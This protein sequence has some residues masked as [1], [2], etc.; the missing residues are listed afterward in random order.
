MNVARLED[1]NLETYGDYDALVVGSRT[2]TSRALHG[3]CRRLAGA[4]T[5]LE[6]A[7]GDRM[8]L[9]LPSGFEL[10][11]AFTAVLRAGGV[12]VV[13][14]PNAPRA[15]IERV[16][17]H[18][19]AKGLIATLARASSLANDPLPLRIVV[20]ANG[21]NQALPDGTH[22]F[23]RLLEHGAPL[24]QAVPRAAHDLAQLI[25]TSGTTGT[26][27]GIVY[28]HGEIALR[29]PFLKAT[30]QINGAAAKPSVR[31]MALPPAHALGGSFFFLRL[32][33]KSTIIC[34]DAFDARQF[35]AAVDRHRVTTTVLVPSMCEALLAEEEI[36]AYD[37]SSLRTIVTGGAP[38]S[39]S[40][41]ERFEAKFKKRLV[42]T[43]GLTEAPGMTLGSLKAK[44]GSAGRLPP[45]VD[46]RFV[47]ADG[48]PLAPGATGEIQFKKH[49]A[50]SIYRPSDGPAG[51]TESDDEWFST[52]DIGYLDADREL[53][54]TGRAKELI[55][56]GGVKINPQEIVDVVLRLGVRECAVVG[57]P[58][59]FLGEEAVACVVPGGAA[60]ITEEEV[61]SHCRAS[62]DKRK[63]PLSVQFFEGLP[64]TELGKIR[65]ESLRQEVLG[66]RATVVE[67]DL[68][69]GLR[70]APPA[71]RR[72]LLRDEIGAQLRRI[73]QREPLVSL[74][75]ELDSGAPFG[76]LGL[77]SLGALELANSLSVAIGRP[78]SATVAFD[79]PTADALCDE[80]LKE[81]FPS[82]G[83]GAAVKPT[84][85]PAQREPVA[86]VGIGC[87]LPG[88]EGTLTDPEAF[89][90]SLRDGIDSTRVVPSERW[91]VEQFYDPARGTPGK[92]Y[93]R[94]GS[95]IDSVDR[96]DADFF[97]ITPSE[98]KGL[99]PQQRLLL[100][101]SWEAL[102]HSGHDPYSLSGGRTG[103][104]VGITGSTYPSANF[105]GVM[106]C[107][108]PGRVSQ[109]LN[110]GG[111]SVAI[112]TACSS[113]LVA[114]HLA[115]QSLRS[116]ECDVAL[117]GGVN[118][119]TSPRPFVYLSAIQALAADGRCKAFDA[120]ADGYGRG[121]G[122]VIVV[123]KPLSL[124]VRDHD[125]IIAVI[126][127]SAVCHDGRRQSLTAPNGAAQ[128][129]VIAA[130]L[131][132]AGVEASAVDYLEAHGTGTPLGDP[133]EVKAAVEVLGQN[134]ERPLIIGS[135]KTN[136]GHTE[137]A[138]GA[139]A[140]A[141]VAL[142]LEHGEIP[143]LLHL[144]HLNPL[145]DPL[146]ESFSMPTALQ[147]WPSTEGRRRLAGVTSLGFS[148]TNAH[149]LIE[150]SPTA[151]MVQRRPG[152][153]AGRAH[154]LC[155]SARS[156]AAL[157]ELV[158]AYG[159]YL[160][161]D[162]APPFADT[163]FTANAGR[164][165]FK[166]RL[167][168]VAPTVS[169]ARERL[170]A[171]V[172]RAP[173]AGGRSA[174]RLKLAFLFTGQGSEYAGMGRQ[175]YETQ[176]T[177]REALQ[178][179]AEVLQP[180]VS[181]PLLDVLFQDTAAGAVNSPPPDDAA[182]LQPALFAF[183]WSLCEL[184]RSWGVEPDLVIGH[185]LGEYVA[186]CVAGLF[187][188]EDGLRLVVERGRLTRELA[189]KG[190]MLALVASAQR[191]E[192]AI[193]VHRDRV[194][195]AAINGRE[196]TV[197]SGNGD[198]LAEIERTLATAGIVNRRLAVGYG[199]HS[200]LM[201]PALDPWERFVS[202]FTFSR[203]RVSLV[204]T[205][206]GSLATYDEMSCPAYWRRHLREPVQFA[207]GVD[208]L[209][210]EGCTAYLEIGPNPVLLGMARQHLAERADAC[211]WLP[212]LRRDRGARE[213]MQES[214]GA[215]YMRGVDPNWSG[216]YADE[217]FS[218]VV[219]PGYPFQRG[220]HWSVPLGVANEMA[221]G[222][223]TVRRAAPRVPQFRAQLSVSLEARTEQLTR[224]LRQI[225]GQVLGCE[226]DS[227]LPDTNLLDSGLDSL[228]AM[229]V[230]SD[231]N[232]SL[233]VVVSPA[234]FFARPTLAALAADLAARVTPG[235]PAENRRPA[236]WAESPLES[237]PLRA[238][239]RAKG[240][241]PLVV[242]HEPG[243]RVPLF[244]IHPAGGQVTAYLRLRPLL[245]DE[246]P[247]FA[248]QSRASESVEREQP[249]LEAMAIDYA[250]VIQGVR[251][252]GPYRLLG[253]SMGGFIAHAVARELELRGESVEQIA[254]IDPRPAAQFDTHDAGLAVVGVMHDLQLAPELGSVLA[255][256]RKLDATP[257]D[258]PK[259][260]SWCQLHG[261]IPKDAISGGTF[262]STVRR[263]LRHFQLLRDHHPGTVDASLVVWWSG[264][265]SPTRY[266]SNY[267]KGELREKVV[268]G[269]H[270]SVMQPP[271]IDVIAAEL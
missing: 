101:V 231:L 123:L 229:E 175:L 49:W 98:A 186:A 70:S 252:T 220:S 54:I 64:K 255:E 172:L 250:T 210:A 13:L 228:R 236:G 72:S 97:G 69:C 8:V 147:A 22:A 31:L 93:T 76:Q 80:L 266:W 75:S 91:D 15:E 143:P 181:R 109:F 30:S 270:F 71:G 187:S 251:P 189:P 53:F 225:V 68:I 217:P 138:A 12:P 237:R 218:R 177:F 32:V 18:C 90:K 246:Q 242:L 47:D 128:Q 119:M 174:N 193:G 137:A 184:W 120:G 10:V 211:L 100:E 146:A 105:L 102:E 81:L 67:T 37:L 106:P 197:V 38:V 126:R 130:A 57:L 204:S 260:L 42:V 78:L 238:P 24:S 267:T 60:R 85:R 111:P 201:D 48:R 258:G 212:S 154:L 232:Q 39:A 176:R 129:A 35:L 1:E 92:T 87:R 194:A 56:Q 178:R 240:N 34:Q 253:W 256:L 156:E 222:G 19:Q 183:E 14:Y 134:R 224:Y 63:V 108:A 205:L 89:W 150:E 200:P 173:R 99:D 265:S 215:L 149:V 141:K 114:I 153:E 95:F 144:R 40:L 2:W 213:Q 74:S 58:H 9:L 160:S 235:E 41:I 122:C 249:T 62:L 196:S 264:G 82:T 135:V 96:F 207:A 50:S 162:P 170:A 241:S 244:C 103:V 202:K 219:V 86:I 6:L 234:E 83:A 239:V 163:C 169:I 142:S 125:R 84:E 230:L 28:T 113:S 33:S 195:I 132:D 167:A 107:M 221:G 110:F 216:F 148:G 104:F 17:A 263:Y 51:A 161:R 226:P 3:H 20:G 140:L 261:L 203:P 268:G 208:R 29:Y 157:G 77:D 271:Y 227:L 133:I 269:T 25:Y 254:M 188:W 131:N 233:N 45:A 27:K 88:K 166:H 223:D 262:T 191:A 94:C 66:R 115:V 118:V 190:G 198:A 44:P 259:L 247:L 199:Y 26:P 168:V 4:L 185:S 180:L 73:L 79:H 23:E 65:T 164:T 16:I 206:S 55:S 36:G 165:H 139:S 243:A 43:Y 121:E 136:I 61:L 159:D 7:P 145:L 127:G 214:L 124:A 151:A 21:G 11:V 158:K 192:Q 171:G 209:L 112:D 152:E 179:C 46:V 155:L 117:A 182:L 5:Q 248:I 257:L 116:G 245:G 52:G 59:S